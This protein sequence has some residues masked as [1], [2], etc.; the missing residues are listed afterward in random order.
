MLSCLQAAADNS[1]EAA[2]SSDCA[3][4]RDLGM[5]PE[6]RGQPGGPAGS[7]N[8][9]ICHLACAAGGAN[10]MALQTCP[11]QQA[12]RLCLHFCPIQP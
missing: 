4:L 1:A 3:I 6:D 12:T 5:L 7:E 10:N 2:L 8:C 11:E 9:M